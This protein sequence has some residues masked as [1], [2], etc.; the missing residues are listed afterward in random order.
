MLIISIKTKCGM[1]VQIKFVIIGV[2]LISGHLYLADTSVRTNGV[3]VRE[4]SLY[5]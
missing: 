1:Y 5:L 4:V 3:R 2:P